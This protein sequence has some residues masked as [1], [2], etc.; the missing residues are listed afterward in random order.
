MSTPTLV[1]SVRNWVHFDNLCTNL[2]KQVT[3]ARN[4]RNRFEE[5]VLGLLGNTKRLRI[6]GAFL[7]PSTKKTSVPLNWTTLEESLHK[8]YTE[9]KKTDETK[10]IIDFLRENRNQKESVYLKKIDFDEDTVRQTNNNTI[11][12]SSAKSL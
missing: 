10:A 12:N 5:Q 1:D 7:E 3:T 4:L 9:T 11:V 6:H 8:Y 2:A